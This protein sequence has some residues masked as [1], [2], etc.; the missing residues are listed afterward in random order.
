MVRA[1]YGDGCRHLC[2]HPLPRLAPTDAIAVGDGFPEASSDADTGL[3]VLPVEDRKQDT[4]HQEG[5][6]GRRH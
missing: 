6:G 4:H 2:R 3:S 5:D 1:G